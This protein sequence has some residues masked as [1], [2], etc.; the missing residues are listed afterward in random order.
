M[1]DVL[2]RAAARQAIADNI[3]HELNLVERWNRY[4]DC[5]I[6]GSVAYQ[7]VVA[8]DIDLEVW[9]REP[10]T[11]SG[12]DVLRECARHPRV[13]R[14]RFWNALGP[15]HH[16]LYWQV[17]YEHAGEEWKIDTWS[18]ANSYS[19]P[20][21]THLTAPMLGALTDR[22]RRSILHLKEAIFRDPELEVPSIQVYRAVLD[23]GVDTLT[24]FVA[25]LPNHRLGG[26]VTEWKPSPRPRT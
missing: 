18:M 2:A 23:H 4:G 9:C 15:P 12:F 21:G 14:A 10:R 19:G 8:P 3:L 22:T 5:Q 25:W 20:C 13:T 6:V 11:E 26:V 7:L 1:D 16:G 24:E 17:R